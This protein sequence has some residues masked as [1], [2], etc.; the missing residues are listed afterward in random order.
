[1]N[2]I[3]KIYRTKQTILEMLE[4]RNFEINKH[5]NFS[6]NEI[7]VMYKAMD[8]KLTTESSPLDFECD[9]NENKC[10]IKFVLFTKLRLA[11]TK[12]IIENM[13]DEYVKSGDTIIFIVKDKINN[14]ESYETILETYLEQ[15]NI[16]IQIFWVDTLLINITKHELV[17]N[18]RIL[19]EDEKQVIFKK[20]NI[21]KFIQLPIIL[22]T[23]PVAKFYGLIR[24]DLVEIIRPSP[25]GGVYKNY[26]YCQ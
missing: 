9:N 14:T 22:K 17:P 8:K 3:N 12:T 1:M 18:M 20:A 13:I 5:K 4:L 7:D 16:K 6:L 15:Y 23:D 21:T 19:N 2:I 26:R 24:G 10:Y 11:N 25:T